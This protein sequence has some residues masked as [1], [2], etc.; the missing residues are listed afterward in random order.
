MKSC[1]LGKAS[2]SIKLTCL[3]ADAMLSANALIP[4]DRVIVRRKHW[5]R[6]GQDQACFHEERFGLAI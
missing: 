3:S 4:N 1:K 6:S 5:I 2:E